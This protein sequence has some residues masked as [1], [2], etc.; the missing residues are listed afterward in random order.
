MYSERFQ[1]QRS[2]IRPEDAWIYHPAECLSLL[3]VFIERNVCFR[4]FLGQFQLPFSLL[5]EPA[6]ERL[7]DGAGVQW[8]HLSGGITQGVPLGDCIEFRRVL[9][10]I[11]H[12]GWLPR[13][14]PS[15]VDY[16]SSRP[17]LVALLGRAHAAR[18]YPNGKLLR[19]TSIPRG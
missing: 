1:R 11:R 2:C 8:R 5:F 7:G 16:G 4:L 10:Y 3:M 14:S 6:L 15:C 18:A 9:V 13:V 12:R 17:T 19:L